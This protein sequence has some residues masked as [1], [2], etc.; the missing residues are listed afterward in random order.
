MARTEYRNVYV[1]GSKVAHLTR[2]LADCNAMSGRVAVLEITIADDGE[3]TVNVED[4]RPP[5][6][7]DVY[8]RRFRS[9]VGLISWIRSDIIENLATDQLSAGAWIGPIYRLRGDLAEI[10]EEES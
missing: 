5:R 6:V 7:A 8:T 9:N 1:N 3:V 10:V 4:T 2:A